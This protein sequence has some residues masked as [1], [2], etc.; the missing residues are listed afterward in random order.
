MEYF[1][2]ELLLVL[3]KSTTLKYYRN[4]KYKIINSIKKY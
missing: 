1:K 3:S 2:F 4:W